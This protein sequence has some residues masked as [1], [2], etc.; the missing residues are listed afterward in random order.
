M[1]AG[2]DDKMIEIHESALSKIGDVLITLQDETIKRLSDAT[3][4][5]EACAAQAEQDRES[6][7]QQREAKTCTIARLLNTIETVSSERDE[8]RARLE[9]A[10]RACAY[11]LEEGRFLV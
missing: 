5:A 3:E 4:A 10:Q 7:E 8:L 9:Q 11:W 2:R 1:N 6:L